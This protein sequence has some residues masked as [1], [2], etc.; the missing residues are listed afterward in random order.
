M[1]I[2]VAEYAVGTGIA[3]HLASEGKLMLDTMV[4]SFK[5][6]SHEVS[7]PEKVND[8]QVY[9]E[10][11]T[12]KC[13]AALVIAPDNILA[14]FTRIVEE[15]TLN[16]GS[17]SEVIEVCADKL[18]TTEV[19]LDNGIHAPRLFTSYKNEV[20][21][22]Q[23]NLR[24]DKSC[25]NFKSENSQIDRYVVKPRWG[26]SSDNVMVVDTFEERE[27]CITC[28]YVSGENVSVSI[29]A[30]GVTGEKL[31][32]TVNYQEMVLE[33]GR[34]K[35]VGGAVPYNI[36]GQD[37]IIDAAMN[38]VEVLGCRGYA[39]VDIVM[40]DHPYVVDVNPRITTSIAGIS[41][42]ID[43]KVGEL[44]ISAALGESLPDV[45]V[46]GSYTWRI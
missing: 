42:V 26:C 13:D 29:I 9:L 19:L 34:I 2:L 23:S 1:K 31:L 11:E 44:I 3:P 22:G 20:F 43:H 10:R 24:F 33:D 6:C 12:R 35:Y 17:P 15:N 36:P 39:G 27:G 37:I 40:A 18:R 14:D 5:K 45:N 38:A 7:Y 46:H 16:L 32:L 25:G 30:S 41:C 8:F 21:A 28:E 4:E